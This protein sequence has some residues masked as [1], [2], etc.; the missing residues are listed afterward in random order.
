MSVLFSY[1][2]KNYLSTK[3]SP[4][5]LKSLINPKTLSENYDSIYKK[6]S[7]AGYR[8]I[9]FGIKEIISRNINVIKREDL[10]KEIDF[11]G[12]V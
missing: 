9:A 5:T 2:G 12:T 11:L 6:H 3:G 1:N 10:E 8:L 4:E 7:F